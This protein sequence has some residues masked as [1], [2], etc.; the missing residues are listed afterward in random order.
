MS[1]HFDAKQFGLLSLDYW[2]VTVCAWRGCCLEV[3]ARAEHTVAECLDAMQG[4]G[5]ELS[6]DAYHPG[7][8]ARLRALDDCLT[9]YTF[10][11]QER[12]ARKRIAQWQT[13]SESRAY[14]AHARIVA[15]T[16]GITIHHMAFDGKARD[17]LSRKTL[18]QLEMLALLRELEEAHRLL[19]SHLG[20][21][22]ARAALATRVP[23]PNQT[24]P[25]SSPG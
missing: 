18:T 14:L 2:P 6:R 10:E 8:A 20:Q 5:L 13:L 7:A 3:F 23:G 1:A 15:T 4:G 21:I 12:T 22:R 24:D 9:R 17:V 16:N 25:G 19:R 11:G